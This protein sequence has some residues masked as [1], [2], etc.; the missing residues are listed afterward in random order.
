MYIYTYVYIIMRVCVYMFICVFPQHHIQGV[1]PSTVL[2][3]TS[4]LSSSVL[5]N[6]QSSI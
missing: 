3:N 4:R 6:L 2:L 5:T 1:C